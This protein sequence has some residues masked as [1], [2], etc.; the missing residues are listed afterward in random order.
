M[1]AQ[2]MTGPPADYAIIGPPQ[3]GKTSLIAALLERAD[4]SYTDHPGPLP[5][6][7]WADEDPAGGSTADA[8]RGEIGQ[9][10]HNG[11]RVGATG[12]RTSILRFSMSLPGERW[13][14]VLRGAAP[15]MTFSVVD[16]GGELLMPVAEVTRDQA[17]AESRQAYAAA[18]RQARGVILCIPVYP[19]APWHQLEG[20]REI[21]ALMRSSRCRLERLVVCLT[22]YEYAT[23]AYGCRAFDLAQR[24]EVFSDRV[25]GE[26]LGPD[27]LESL[28][29]LASS[30]AQRGGPLDIAITPLSV[31]GF[32]HRNGCA[33]FDLWHPHGSGGMLLQA[34]APEPQSTPGTRDWP[35]YE[36]SEVRRLWVPYRIIEPFTY[37]LT[38]QGGSLTIPLERLLR[39]DAT[40]RS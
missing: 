6:F 24:E 5:S 29:V 15:P 33:N 8:L 30:R 10:I 39:R 28:R 3:S 31:Y 26:V 38:G 25:I 17:Y 16:G 34:A 37:L 32:I 23:A 9:A 40:A 2:P 4:S 11:G 13:G 1:S 21:M 35:L 20:M 18:L 27:F 7:R 36:A 22:K 14:G 19:G 12:S